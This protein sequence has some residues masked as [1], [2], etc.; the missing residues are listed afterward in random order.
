M[1]G[2]FIHDSY[3]GEWY[4]GQLEQTP[5]YIG[6]KVSMLTGMP[7]LR[8][9]RIQEGKFLMSIIP[10]IIIIIFVIVLVIIS[11]LLLLSLSLSLSLLLLLLLLLL[12]SYLQQN[13]SS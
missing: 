6:N 10:I 4:N 2:K 8:Q 3:A 13:S 7:R 11:L 1:L 5:E 12:L 9:L